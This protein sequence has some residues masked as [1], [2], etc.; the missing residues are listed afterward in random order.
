[1]A[2]IMVSHGRFLMHSIYTLHVESVLSFLSSSSNGC[3]PCTDLSSA[4]T[5]KLRLG[6]PAYGRFADWEDQADE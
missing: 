6:R 2:A 5:T 1:M 3:F 4:F